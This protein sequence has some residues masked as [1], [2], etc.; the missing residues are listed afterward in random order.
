[1]TA[2]LPP[3][4][5]GTTSSAPATASTTATMSRAWMRP[6]PASAPKRRR[7]TPYVDNPIAAIDAEA[8]LMARKYVS[9]WPKKRNPMSASRGATA[10]E[11]LRRSPRKAERIRTTVVATPNR[12]IPIVYAF[13]CTYFTATGMHPKRARAKNASTAVTAVRVGGG[14]G[15]T[16]VSGIRLIT[17]G[18]VREQPS[19]PRVFFYLL[20]DSS[21]RAI[22]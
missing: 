7:S 20:C 6:C 13:A 17:H 9:Q 10:H 21:H 8:S 1:M 2:A 14:G 11:S 18:D 15:G 5:S 4:R 16:W 3:R 19:R 12:K 22:V